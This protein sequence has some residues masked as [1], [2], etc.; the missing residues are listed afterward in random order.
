MSTINLGRVEQIPLGEGRAFQVAGEKIA[1][2]RPRDGGLFATEAVCPHRQGP[3]ADGLVGG[4]KVYCPLHGFAFD[5]ASGRSL[6]S[7]S[8][9]ARTF[10]VSL[11]PQGDNLHGAPGSNGSPKTSGSLAGRR[12]ALL[13]AR[14][15]SEAAALVR[16]LGGLPVSVPALREEP[17]F[18]TAMVRSFLENLAAGEIAIVIFQTGVGV[19]AL[20]DE[21]AALGSEQALVDGLASVVTVSRGPKPGG[22]L[23]AR[24]LRPTFTVPTPY[25][26]AEVLAVLAPLPVDRAGVA[27]INYGE[28]NEA[29]AGALEERG[30]RTFEL[31]LYEW[32]LP[33]DTAPLMGLV[34][35]ILAAE[36]DAVTFTTQVQ[37]RHLFAVTDPR[38]RPALVEALD[39]LV[40]TGAVG[41]TCA[42]ALRA[43]GVED[44]VVPENPKLGPLFAALAS[45][46][47]ARP[48]AADAAAEV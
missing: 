11:S 6:N 25:T 29:L 30:A 47:A 42:Q 24:G 45:R 18:A 28:R 48:R 19:N 26:T 7:T 31:T 44:I 13:E 20:F 3:L 43:F 37:V 4:G 23:A 21:A 8:A 1:V 35:Q 15:A 12:V 14:L 39:R 9:G 32:R 38:V 27:I 17:V 46:L 33:E 40:V 22:A 10:K 41:P 5:H 16:R 36:V 34:D 2:F